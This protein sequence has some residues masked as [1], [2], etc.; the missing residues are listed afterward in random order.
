MKDSR[1]CAGSPGIFTTINGRSVVWRD[2][3]GVLHNCEGADVHQGVRLI[4]TR[5]GKRDVPADVAFHPEVDDCVTCPDCLLGTP[6]LTTNTTPPSGNE[7]DMDNTIGTHNSEANESATMSVLMRDPLY[8]KWC[9]QNAAMTAKSDKGEQSDTDEGTYWA[10]LSENYPQQVG[11]WLSVARAVAGWSQPHVSTAARQIANLLVLS[12]LPDSD[13]R[14]SPAAA[15]ARMERVRAVR[16][17][18]FGPFQKAVEDA[19]NEALVVLTAIAAG[20][21]AQS[22]PDA[23]LVEALNSAIDT[24]AEK[25]DRLAAVKHE[26]SNFDRED[27]RVEGLRESIGIIAAIRA[28]QEARDA[29]AQVHS[30]ALAGV[31]LNQDTP[32]RCPDCGWC[33][34]GVDLGP[35]GAC[36]GEECQGRPTAIVSQLDMIQAWADADGMVCGPQLVALG[37]LEPIPGTE[38]EARTEWGA[39]TLWGLTAEGEAILRDARAQAALRAEFDAL[40]EEGKGNG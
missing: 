31:A 37:L 38:D 25:A 32:V 39:E 15:K 29:P 13:E 12:R 14:P 16:P 24:I 18:D 26:S 21:E 5:C 11:V 35:D 27:G 3:D 10:W 30:G 4:W 2:G 28:R 6:N 33:G 36:G 17:E 20:D 23:A 22:Q 40:T 8:L 1:G 34:H 9:E 19:M 7:D